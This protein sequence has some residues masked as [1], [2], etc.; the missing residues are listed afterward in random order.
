M[1]ADKGKSADDLLDEDDEDD[2]EKDTKDKDKAT[3]IITINP[4]LVKKIKYCDK[5]IEAHKKKIMRDLAQFMEMREDTRNK[6]EDFEFELEQRYCKNLPGLKPEEINKAFT[7]SEIKK[8]SELRQ[9]IR[10]IER[11]I[12][13]VDQRSPAAREISKYKYLR[14]EYEE[15]AC[16]EAN[17]TA[18]AIDWDTGTAEVQ[19]N[20]PMLSDIEKQINDDLAK[21][22]EPSKD[23]K[24]IEE[25]ET[26]LKHN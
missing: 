9:K 20:A 10:R 17:V 21:I 18:D 3:K 2:D 1:A 25:L 4:V 22:P 7:S 26:P 24:V 11:R 14:D 5:R 15:Q 19:A 16:V 6:T 13:F 12:V 8:W 23:E